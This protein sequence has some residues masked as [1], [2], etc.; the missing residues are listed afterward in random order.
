MGLPVKLTFV[1]VR[2]I[3]ALRSVAVD[4]ASSMEMSVRVANLV[5]RHAHDAKGSR[6]S[7]NLYRCSCAQEYW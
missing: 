4:V 7:A 6:R 5:V 1:P 2:S 3:I